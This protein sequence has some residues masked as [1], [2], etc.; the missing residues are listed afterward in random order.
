LS[1]SF[2]RLEDVVLDDLFPTVDLMLRRG[3]HVGREDDT[4]YAFLVDALDHL[5][6]LYRRYGAELVH[7]SDGYF[8]LLPI[9]DRLG[10]AQLSAA[11]ML[12]GQALALL[13]L[14]P[15]S[16]KTTGVVAREL[17]LQRLSGL[18]GD[19]ALIRA[20]K[21]GRRKVDERVAAATVRASVSTAVRALADLGFVDLVDAEHFRL[22][23]ALMR[24]TDPVRALSD[25][26]GAL[27][28]LIARGE[29]AS[30]TEG[31]STEVDDGE[32]DGE[33]P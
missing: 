12:V 25:Q 27:E 11:E 14:D 23:R 3:R 24:F 21:R 10:R 29:I 15:S 17:L 5:E 28:R 26:A 6:P 2:Q 8:Y 31:S 13:Y 18:V 4:L 30:P 16:V 22:R 33:A 1:S 9:G 19:E 32:P 7:K 20:L